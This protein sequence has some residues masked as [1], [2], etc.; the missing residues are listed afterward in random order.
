MMLAPA[1]PAIAWPKAL[2]VRLI[3][4]TPARF[5]VVKS[6]TWEPAVSA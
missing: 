5:V 3:A 2:P 6:S 4:V 1:L